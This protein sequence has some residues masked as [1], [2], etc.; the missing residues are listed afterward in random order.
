M[1]YQL[2][3]GDVVGLLGALRRITERNV[4][5]VEKVLNRYFRER[6]SLEPVSRKSNCQM[7]WIGRS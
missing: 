4:G 6:D 1:L 2:S 5:A 3:D 7:L